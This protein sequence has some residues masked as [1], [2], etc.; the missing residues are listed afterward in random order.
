VTISLIMWVYYSAV[1]FVVGA[2][3]IRVLEE[4]RQIR[5]QV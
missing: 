5:A 3:V 2:N 4:R 1:V